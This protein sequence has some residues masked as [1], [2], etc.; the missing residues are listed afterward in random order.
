MLTRSL[1]T[2]LKIQRSWYSNK[3]FPK[4]NY[5]GL[6]FQFSFATNKNVS[7]DISDFPQKYV[8]DQ[9]ESGWYEWWETNGFFKCQENKNAKM[10]KKRFSMILP[11]PNVT[12]YLHL[13][14]ALTAT[15]QDATIR[16]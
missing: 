10:K 2:Q 12:G 5:F 3:V 4:G 9:V 11:P 13:G 7:K 15:I 6:T 14:H 8:S 16:W 1:A